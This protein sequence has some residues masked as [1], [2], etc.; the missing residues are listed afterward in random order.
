MCTPLA[1]AT[2]LLILLVSFCPQDACASM[3]VLTSFP[4]IIV[5]LYWFVYC[6]CPYCLQWVL[7]ICMLPPPC[8]LVLLLYYCFDLYSWIV[9]LC[10]CIYPTVYSEY[11]FYSLSS[12]T[13]LLVFVFSC[14]MDDLFVLTW[15]FITCIIVLLLVTWN[16]NFDHWYWHSLV[17][18]LL[19]QLLRAV[20]PALTLIMSCKLRQTFFL[21]WWTLMFCWLLVAWWLWCSLCCSVPYFYFRFS[22]YFTL[23]YFIWH[24]KLTNYYFPS[25]TYLVFDIA[26]M[27][28]KFFLPPPST[29]ATEAG[30]VL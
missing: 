6:I 10:Y 27:Y 15:C 30:L 8:L 7:V 17:T 22:N 18:C 9:L 4:C 1:V 25:P 26:C 29:Y 16:I 2:D 11:R 20:A 13:C 21:L 24:F 23:H 19:P 28:F 3:D 5:L 12:P 14:R